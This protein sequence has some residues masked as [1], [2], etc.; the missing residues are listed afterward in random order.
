MFEAGDRLTRAADSELLD[1]R[2]RPHPGHCIHR[3]GVSAG[4]TYLVDGQYLET[5][6]GIPFRVSLGKVGSGLLMQL[7][8]TRSLETAI[9][10]VAESAPGIS[11]GEV[12]RR[13][14]ALM[15]ELFGLGFLET[16][17]QQLDRVKLE[18][19]ESEQ[20]IEVMVPK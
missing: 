15:R 19:A 12:R 6:A 10:R 17:G 18:G 20:R 4:A 13:G 9:A 11:S 14:L 16:A 3:T 2:F 8:G 5:T 7:D 1:Y